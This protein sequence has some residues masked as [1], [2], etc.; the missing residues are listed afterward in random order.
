M[1]KLRTYPFSIFLYGGFL[2]LYS[3]CLAA[4]YIVK[5]D[6][7]LFAA[8]AATPAMHGLVVIGEPLLDWAGSVGSPSRTMI[9]WLLIFVAGT[10][11]LLLGSILDYILRS[12]FQA[13]ARNE[14]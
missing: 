11:Y 13:E 14:T 9:E 7:I 2:L 8:F 12:S 3:Y 5:E 1:V 4:F 10:Q 6:A